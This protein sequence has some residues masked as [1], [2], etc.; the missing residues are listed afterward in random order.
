MKTYQVAYSIKLTRKNVEIHSKN[1]FLLKLINT[2]RRHKT[3]S[4]TNA[5]L[6]IL[7]IIEFIVC[8]VNCLYLC[9]AGMLNTVCIHG[10]LKYPCGFQF[11]CS[12]AIFFIFP[13]LML[14]SLWKRVVSIII[15]GLLIIG[16]LCILSGIAILLA[17]LLYIGW[18][19]SKESLIPSCSSAWFM[20]L[21]PLWGVGCLIRYWCGKKYK[22]VFYS[23]SL[24]KS[25]QENS[26]DFLIL[27]VS[28]MLYT[29]IY[30]VIF[31]YSY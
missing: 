22:Y 9:A 11:W 8:T 30:M 10:Y 23:A 19:E 16:F 4:N 7:M 27:F 18:W 6:V 26:R 28:L 2:T 24:I 21:I 13:L 1:K 20:A 15:F 14:L 12:F 31:E 17:Y 3:T 29:L 25:Y 5:W